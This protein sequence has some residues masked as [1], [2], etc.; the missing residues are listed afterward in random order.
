[1]PGQRPSGASVRKPK[2]TAAPVA[3]AVVD[4]VMMW[5]STSRRID[6]LW[7]GTYSNAG[8]VMPRVEEALAL[9]KTRD[10]LRYRRIL[11]DVGR[12]WV[13]LTPGVAARFK[14]GIRTCELD[15]RFVLAETSSPE[16]IAAVIVHEATHARLEHRGI[17][18]DERIRGRVEGVCARRE[19]AFAKLLPDGEQAREAAEARLALPL[20]TW[21][22]AAGLERNLQASLEILRDRGAPSWMIRWAER[23]GRGKA[24]TAASRVT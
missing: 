7:V 14:F 1:M 10:P 4:R 11:K 5:L 23:R 13:N 6:G 2:P 22:D 12:V 20:A 9:I 19:L 24:R 17:G 15:E 21:T 8:Q 18:Y 3:S 16:A